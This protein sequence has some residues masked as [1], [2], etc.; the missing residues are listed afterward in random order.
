M[1]QQPPQQWRPAPPRRKKK[2]PRLV[3]WIVAGWLGVFVV[4]G[5]LV[6][7][8]DPP[9]DPVAAVD[10]PSASASSSPPESPAP[11]P[12]PP[13]HSSDQIDDGTWQVP[14]EAKPGL[15]RTDG[16]A[17]G[18]SCYWARLKGLG[19]SVDDIIA[20]GS[21]SGPTTVRISKGDAGFETRG[22]LSWT[23]VG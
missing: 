13:S 6:D 17:D 2:V 16:P 21:P 12:P 11:L 22:C 9:K 3:W 5:V 19:G 7:T 8:F 10:S 20:N 14:A 4:G 1:Y 23:K 18:S 15:Y